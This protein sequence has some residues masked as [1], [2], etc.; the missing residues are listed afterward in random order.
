MDLHGHVLVVDDLTDNLDIVEKI[1]VG[2][3]Y[4]T[5]RASSGAEALKIVHTHRFDAILSDVEMPGLD[6]WALCRV[7][8][9]DPRTSGIPVVFMTARHGGDEQVVRALAM[10][11]A[12]YV[13]KPVHAEILVRRIDVL[14]R[15]HRA[16]A[17]QRLLAED[18]ADALAAL[19]AAQAQALEARKLSGLSTMARGL[20]H[21]INN[22][23]AAALSEVAYVASGRGTIEDRSE[24]LAAAITSL[25]RV[26]HIVDR[27]RRLGDEVE[28][29]APTAL[30]GVV[31][32]SVEPLV[33]LLANRGILVELQLDRVP[34]FA[35]AGR[36][37]P[38]IAELVTNAGRASPEGSRILVNLSLRDGEAHLNVR[39]EGSGMS[40]DAVRRAFDPFYTQKKDWRAIGLGLPM[41]HSVVSGLGGTIDISSMPGKGTEVAIIVPIR[42][43]APSM[44]TPTVGMIG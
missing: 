6:G 7:L 20:A 22:P 39:D 23:L 2:A 36:I 25:E 29:S 42:P 1:L 38:V 31:R 4:T 33:P 43:A 41:C 16:E 21:E 14:V 37:S 5:V 27:M 32:A 15:A 12:D 24:A 17:E 8:K 10:G 19:G 26:K 35:N 44:V 18:R 3:G 11:G 13:N 34:P 9:A 30:E 28:T 40:A